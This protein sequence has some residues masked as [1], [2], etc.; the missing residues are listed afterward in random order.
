M[1]PDV[2]FI[3]A[4]V[5]DKNAL[6]SEATLIAGINYAVEHNADI[7]SISAGGLFDDLNS[8]VVSAVEEAINN[9]ILVVVASGNCGQGCTKCGNFIGVATP[10]NAP[11]A[12]TVGA[13]NNEE[14]VCYSSGKNYNNYIKPDI[15][16]PE[17]AN[18]LTGTSASTP[19][20]TGAAALIL[21]KYDASPSQV[22]SLLE[23]NAFD[24]GSEGKDTVFG[25]G[26]L[27]LS[28]ILEAELPERKA[29]QT[30]TPIQHTQTNRV[31]QGFSVSGTTTAGDWSTFPIVK[32]SLFYDFVYEHK[33]M[34]FY[35]ETFGYLYDCLSVYPFN[36]TD[37]FGIIF[38]G[39]RGCT[40][41]SR[42][43]KIQRG[44]IKILTPNSVYAAEGGKI[45]YYNGTMWSNQTVPL[46]NLNL[47]TIDAN[48]STNLVG[49]I[50]STGNGT[51]LK[52]IG[53]SWTVEPGSFAPIKRIRFVNATLA[54]AIGSNLTNPSIGQKI[55]KW[56]NGAWS[57]D[58]SNLAPSGELTDLEA[59]SDKLT[60]A[61]G[62]NGVMMKWDGSS[63]TSVST[64][65]T[66]PLHGIGFYNETLGYA[67][68]ANAT[69]LKYDGTWSID[70][71]GETIIDPD[72]CKYVPSQSSDD[73]C[74]PFLLNESIFNDVEVFSPTSGFI[75]ASGVS[76]GQFFGNYLLKLTPN[77]P[78]FEL[79]LFDMDQNSSL[80]INLNAYSDGDSFT[81]D[82]GSCSIAGNQ[83]TF[84]P[85]STFT[86]IMSCVVT[87]TKN[88]LTTTKGLLAEVHPIGPVADLSVSS[89]DISVVD[90]TGIEKINVTIHN[91]GRSIANSVSVK[92]IETRNNNIIGS[93]TDVITSIA[94]GSKETL[95]MNL[96]VLRGSTLTAIADY[97]NSIVEF[98]EGNNRADAVYKKSD[99]YLNITVQPMFADAIISYLLKSLVNYNI[100]S[101]SSA[102]NVILNVGYNY[103]DSQ[104]GCGTGTVRSLGNAVMEAYT[105]MI[106]TQ[107]QNGKPVTT[108]CGA[109]IEGVVNAVRRL[110]K[111]DVTKHKETFFDRTDLGAISVFDFFSNN[112]NVPMPNL[113][114]DALN[115]GLELR[116]DYVETM[117][118]TL[119]R[120]KHY[121]PIV[122]QTFLDFLFGLNDS[123]PWLSPVVMAG[124]LWSDITAWEEAGKEIASGVEDKLLGDSIEYTPRDVWLIE[125]TGGPGTECSTCVDY[126]YDDVVDKH[127]PAL[128]GG[129]L[130]LTGKSQTAYVGHSNGGRVALDGLKNWSSG[131]SPAG[132]L[133]NGIVFNLP[134]NPVDTYVGVG[135]PGAFNGSILT[136]DLIRQNANQ[137]SNEL[138][139]Q[140][141]H[142]VYMFDIIKRGIFGLSDAS[143]NTKATIST[144]LW[145][146]Y[147]NLITSSLDNQPGNINIDK[148][149]IVGGH[150]FGNSD[151]I[152]LITDINS[153][154]NNI[155][156]NTG[157]QNKKV[158]IYLPT[159]HSAMR[160]A[161][162]IKTTIKQFLND[163][164]MTH[165][166]EN[167]VNG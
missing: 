89:S 159:L 24:L 139:S 57:T 164:K 39:D 15:V 145:N 73:Y 20:V 111:E 87:A 30:P 13:V 102:A 167:Q 84:T 99:I 27:D 147:S 130:K 62:T 113:V 4:K 138:A 78:R 69:I 74:V 137:I 98:T 108:I 129:V 151:G 67:V 32:H 133:S 90:T 116:E 123:K 157:S 66:Q 135:V 26:K 156:V 55:Y 18:S 141:L 49:G 63:W 155:N 60:F 119:L 11:N 153:I 165:K 96:D 68:G 92:L 50:D 51:I 86:G 162:S 121:K 42:E 146:S 126:T 21:E 2:E 148:S 77:A 65:T 115:G 144:N 149:L 101:D 127:W 143:T 22:K 120:L 7:I 6:G 25:S 166:I 75:I 9:G 103:G 59:V 91:L 29:V 100:I 154:F 124:G 158:L 33:R 14:P 93:T 72:T 161:P 122:S 95:T 94:N 43:N 45:F 79:P 46:S 83:L 1:A 37:R 5:L 140:N 44:E 112:K 48:G 31:I 136:L 40:H 53:A 104:R 114:A 19:F 80:T 28:S 16:A 17:S 125:L 76:D 64:L 152:V 56:S 81:K 118:G 88:G 163:E 97:T 35:N 117:D 70:S 142:H 52:K 71:E 107:E 61:I 105:G 41:N 47:V 12:I 132:K 131:K 160:T 106:F 109:R 3:N 8:P 128:V 134:S 36:G 110:N 82:S 34:S 54:F 10:G 23:N 38:I 85:S 58:Y 150:L